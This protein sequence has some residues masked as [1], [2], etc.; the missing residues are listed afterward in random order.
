[1]SSMHTFVEHIRSCLRTA[2]Y[3]AFI[4][5][6]EDLRL[7]PPKGQMHG[8]WVL[9]PTAASYQAYDLTEA[10]YRVRWTL[11][12]LWSGVGTEVYAKALQGRNKAIRSILDSARP[13]TILDIQV[14]Y[15]DSPMETRED[16]TEVSVTINCVL[17]GD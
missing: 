6:D 17:T 9:I 10:K 8:V 3:P 15:E 12:S 11:I 1:M 5:G 16:R 13:A 2:G 7:L 14:P 4:A